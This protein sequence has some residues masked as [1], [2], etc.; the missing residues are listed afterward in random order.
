ML[1]GLQ[2][3]SREGISHL[4]RVGLIPRYGRVCCEEGVFVKRALMSKSKKGEH[5]TV[6]S[7]NL[8]LHPPNTQLQ[9]QLWLFTLIHPIHKLCDHDLI[10]QT[11]GRDGGKHHGR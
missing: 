1:Q 3:Y 6:S 2:V 11:L 8:L 9:L 7:N 5:I 4:T 10:I